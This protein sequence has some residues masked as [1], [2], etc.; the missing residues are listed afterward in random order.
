MEEKVYKKVQL[1]W[2]ANAAIAGEASRLYSPGTV[3]QW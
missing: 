2:R 3:W 1:I